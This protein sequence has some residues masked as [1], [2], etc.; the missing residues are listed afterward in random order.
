MHGLFLKK[1]S[2]ITHDGRKLK[3]K[4]KKKKKK[5]NLLINFKEKEE[6]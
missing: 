2:S 3:K 5:K 4:K 6:P 1:I